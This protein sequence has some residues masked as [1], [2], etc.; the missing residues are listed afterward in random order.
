MLRKIEEKEKRK[1]RVHEGVERLLVGPYDPTTATSMKT[2]LKNRL[3]ILSLFFRDYS[4]SPRIWVEA[5][6]KRPRPNSDR[7]GRIYRLA[8]PVPK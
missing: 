6:E 4:K 3:P 1:N 2:S 8:V 7:D 5:E